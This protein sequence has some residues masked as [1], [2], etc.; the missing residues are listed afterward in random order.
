MK[1][2][3]DFIKDRPE[4]NTPDVSDPLQHPS[5]R[6][7]KSATC[8]PT[9]SEGLYD[10]NVTVC[11]DPAMRLSPYQES[12]TKLSQAISAILEKAGSQNIQMALKTNA[13]PDST[14]PNRTNE[15]SIG[16]SG[17]MDRIQKAL[18]AMVEAGKTMAASTQQSAG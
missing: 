4:G 12:T 6:Y 15:F 16:A 14:D 17:E 10:V 11:V 1:K 13:D 8:T 18:D 9:S 2:P 5:L 7:V 3:K